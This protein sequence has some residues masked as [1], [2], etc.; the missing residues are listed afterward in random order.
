[1]LVEEQIFTSNLTK[2]SLALNTIM[3]NSLVIVVVEWYRWGLYQSKSVS[4]LT[5]IIGTHLIIDI[6]YCCTIPLVFFQ[7]RLN[8]KAEVCFSPHFYVHLNAKSFIHAF[9]HLCLVR[10]W[11]LEGGEKTG[12]SNIFFQVLVVRWYG[13]GLYQSKSIGVWLVESAPTY[14]FDSRHIHTIKMAFLKLVGFSLHNC[15]EDPMAASE[16][17]FLLRL[18]RQQ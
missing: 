6:I 10:L 17:K 13:W 11:L 14:F 1:M 8:V 18:S 5:A 4:G 3:R 7:S 15:P 12:E 9:M 2:T 16:S